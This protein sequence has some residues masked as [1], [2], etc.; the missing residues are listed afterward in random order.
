MSFN[1]NYLIL[2]AMTCLLWVD[3]LTGISVYYGVGLTGLSML[4]KL[5][6]LA[7]V[8]INIGSY[9]PKL[10][11]IFLSLILILMIGPTQSFLTFGQT[12]YYFDDFSYAL[13]LITPIVVFSY[14]YILRCVYPELLRRW[15]PIILF[16][17]FAAVI[18][19]LVLGKLGFGW[20]SYGGTSGQPG[21]G[22]NGFYVAGNELSAC[23][24]LLYGFVLHYVWITQS[25]RRYML[26]ALSALYFGAAIATKTAMLAS[27]MLVFLVPLIN[28]RR[29]LFKL[30][31]LK[32]ALL[33]PF[34]LL[35]TAIIL[36]IETVLTR[37]GLW[38]KFTWIISEKGWLT[39]LVSGR[40]EK[41][42]QLLNYFE[43]YAAT[44]DYLWG[45]GASGITHFE[46]IFYAAEVDPIDIF[47]WFGLF[48][49]GVVVT[50]IFIMNF[51]AFR[52][53]RSSAF[54]P[55]IIV[56]VNLVLILLSLISGHIWA[57]GMLGI[58]W[59]VFNGLIFVQ[60]SEA[61]AT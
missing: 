59:G 42:V 27:L 11:L 14:L 49:V 35:T 51:L 60:R 46:S 36:F 61:E 26:V 18:F 48:G 37:I 24:V 45:I 25:K 50:A 44:S 5:L 57:S 38:E 52:S 19:N 32:L 47:I 21:I 13:K 58:I 4:Y 15:L 12:N 29:N 9:S 41:A 2:V 33:G 20:P 7:L 1:L 6:I 28:E 55:P 8:F 43:D 30:T 16:S 17:S 39:L 40:D 56:L 31:K 3:T 53:I 23:F 34:V 10:L 22:V 54:Y